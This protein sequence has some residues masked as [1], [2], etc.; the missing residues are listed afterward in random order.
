MDQL[1]WYRRI[2]ASAPPANLQSTLQKA[3]QGDAESQFALG[4]KFS[5][6]ASARDLT[7]AARWYG[8]AAEQNHVLAQFNLSVMFATG[9]GVTQD[10]STALVW[11]RKAAEGGDA[12][13]QFRLGSRCHRSSI[14]H[15]EPNAL[16]R[17]VEAYK[18]F[19]LAAQQGYQGS[20]AARERIA[21]TMSRDEVT[22]GDRQAAAF[23]IRPAMKPENPCCAIAE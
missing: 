18:W 19:H 12:G 3:E 16:E 6:D 2:F 9:Q 22:D 1:P 4:L 7:E 17:R 20:A 10:D 21:L 23:T 15:L 5:T 13:A 11:I 8:K 14:D